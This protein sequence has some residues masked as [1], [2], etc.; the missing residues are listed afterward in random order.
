[1]NWWNTYNNEVCSAG[2]SDLYLGRFER[3]IKER[4]TLGQSFKR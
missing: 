3:V 4:V 1:M 2:Y